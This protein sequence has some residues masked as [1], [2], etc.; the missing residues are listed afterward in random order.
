MYWVV[1]WLHLCLWRMHL[2]TIGRKGVV[3][4]DLNWLTQSAF[5]QYIK[6][7]AYAQEAQVF[8]LLYITK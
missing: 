6:Y 5:I 1:V 8:I 3:E 2:I 4:Y 7:N